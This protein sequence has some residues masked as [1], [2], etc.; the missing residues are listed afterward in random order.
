MEEAE[1]AN[2]TLSIHIENFNP[3]LK[4]FQRL[5][6]GKAGENGFSCLMEWHAASP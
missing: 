6:F 3:S 4:L 2:K 5:G 1:A